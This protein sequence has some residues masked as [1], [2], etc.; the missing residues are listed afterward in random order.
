MQRLP[1]ETLN[2]ILEY[3]NDASDVLRLSSVMKYFNIILG[4]LRRTCFVAGHAL[5][6]PVSQIWP[7]FDPD[8]KWGMIACILSKDV[9]R[10]YALIRC[11]DLYGGI[12]VLKIARPDQIRDWNEK[13]LIAKR[14]HLH[15]IDEDSVPLILAEIPS[16]YCI[17]KLDLPN[18]KNFALSTVTRLR[19]T[20]IEHLDLMTAD[21]CIVAALPN[22][23]GLRIVTFRDVVFSNF[24]WTLLLT[25]CTELQELTFVCTKGSGYKNLPL[26]LLKM[27]NLSKVTFNVYHHSQVQHYIHDLESINWISKFNPLQQNLVVW[28][29]KK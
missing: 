23:P 11:L 25:R 21:L 14:L 6:L 24:E 12:L 28:S 18:Q 22:I 29:R 5:G 8:Y 19:K 16:H 9:D 2:N 7:R 17:F 3:V 10:V 15:I 1:P 26:K 4:H 20:C 13:K 27:S